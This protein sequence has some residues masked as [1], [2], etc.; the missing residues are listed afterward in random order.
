[1]MNLNFKIHEFPIEYAHNDERKSH[2][3]IGDLFYAIFLALLNFSTG[4]TT[5]V[6][7]MIFGF[8]LLFG[9]LLFLFC[10]ILWGMYNAS[11]LP[12]NLLLFD[13]VLIFIGV[14]FVFL[15]M[16]VFKIERVNK[17]LDFRKSINQRIEHEN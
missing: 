1:M 17:N 11:V 5:L 4:A 12:T 15:S 9:G 14:Q 10:I 6:F 13:F 2:Y 7:L 8:F 3:K 16:I